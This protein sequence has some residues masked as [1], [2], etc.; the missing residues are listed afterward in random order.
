M[1]P[2]RVRHF[3]RVADE[4][5]RLTVKA[6]IGLYALDELDALARASGIGASYWIIRVMKPTTSG[7]I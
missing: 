7:W 4:V 6:W 2:L 5:G 1:P 3:H